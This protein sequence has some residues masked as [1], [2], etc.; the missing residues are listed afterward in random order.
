MIVR[1]EPYVAISN[2]DG[3]FEIK[4]MPEG[5]WK[6]QFWHETTGY[7]S[8]L[9][10]DGKPVMDGRPATV[11]ITIKNGEVTDMGDLEIAADSLDAK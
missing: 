11:T 2:E 9:M 5:E 10:Q 3:T 1:D 6:F 8:D 7:M 4:N